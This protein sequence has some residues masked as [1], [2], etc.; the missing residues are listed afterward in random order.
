MYEIRHF[1]LKNHHE[2]EKLVLVSKQKRMQHKKIN[3]SS[4]PFLW[5]YHPA[6]CHPN[7]RTVQGNFTIH[8]KD[9]KIIIHVDI[10]DIIIYY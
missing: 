10:D 5:G 3:R 9:I 7:T 4:L 2:I 6:V 1:G 8:E